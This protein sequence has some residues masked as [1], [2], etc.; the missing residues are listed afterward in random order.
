MAITGK[1]NHPGMVRV[2]QT[3]AELIKPFWAKLAGHRGDWLERRVLRAMSEPPL[4]IIDVTTQFTIIIATSRTRP[5]LVSGWE[6]RGR[7]LSK[8]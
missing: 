7:R 3:G 4:R 2:R 6:Y 5:W 1:G 8:A